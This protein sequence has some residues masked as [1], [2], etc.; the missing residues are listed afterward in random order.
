MKPS[1]RSGPA[2]ALAATLIVTVTIPATASAGPS[3]TTWLHCRYT[4]QPIEI[5]YAFDSSNGAFYAY[6]PKA[7]VLNRFYNAIVSEQNIDLRID[8]D[9]MRSDIVIDRRTLS[10]DDTS[11]IEL[12]GGE[13]SYSEWVGVCQKIDPMPQQAPQF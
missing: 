3:T 10:I 2:A 1:I 5:T 8:T 13:P 7:Q 12:G 11:K 6:D 9:R 4:D